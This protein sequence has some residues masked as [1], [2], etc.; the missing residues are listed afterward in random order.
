MRGPRNRKI[1][2]GTIAVLLSSVIVLGM[3]VFVWIRLSDG[4]SVDLSRIRTGVLDLKETNVKEDAEPMVSTAERTVRPVAPVSTEKPSELVR[5]YTM[6]IGGTVALDGEVRKNSWYSDVKQYDY[7]DIMTLLKREMQSDLNIVFLENLLTEDGRSSDVTA[8][9]AAAAMLKGAGFNVAACGFSKSYEKEKAGILTTR[10]L[11][12]EHSITPVGI[13]ETNEDNHYRITDIKGIRT[14]ILQYTGTISS[15]TRKNMSKNGT[16]GLVPAAEA[17]TIKADINTVR[18][19][20]SEVVIVLLNWGKTGKA[21]D[22]TMHV[23][24]QKIADA[25]ADLIIG[26]GSRIVSGAEMLTAENTGKQVLCVWS[27]G[28]VL[29]GD[30]S[31]IRRMAGV[32]LQAEARSEGGHTTLCEYR[33]IP[34]YTWK[35]KQD[36][37]FYYRCLA[38]DEAIPDGMDSEQQKM[39]KKAEDTVR[40]AMAGSPVEVRSFE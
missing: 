29:S 26:N 10:K 30:R 25:G 1:S 20:G 6:T 15:A 28:T 24:A 3:T 2:T 31:N 33:Y 32:L 14:A 35:Y 27:L 7:Y 37:R 18:S 8:T 40:N 23:L 22:K 39:M 9:N 21:P 34:I 12:E 16:S 17:E 38:A 4:K 36:S 5:S 13:Y 19:R 11:L